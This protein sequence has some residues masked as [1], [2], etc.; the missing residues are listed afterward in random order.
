MPQTGAL[1]AAGDRGAR[2]PGHLGGVRPHARLG[3]HPA[4]RRGGRADRS[5]SSSPAISVR[6]ARPSSRTFEPFQQADMVFLESTYGDH[7]HRPFDGN[8]GGVRPHREGHG[9]AARQD[10]RARRSPWA[11]RNCSPACS[12]GCS[13]RRR[14]GPSPSSSTAPW[15]SRPPNI[16]A[17]HRELFDDAM[18]KFIAEKPLRDDLK[19]MKLCVTAEDSMKINDAARALP[20]HGRRRHVQ[21]RPHPAPPEAQPLESRTPTC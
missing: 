19:T 2:H 12:P 4:D 13:A 16:Y 10:P 6:E 20:G 8:G 3:Q 1:S 17:R 7:D 9:R 18:T 21:R 14:S 11:A 15:P 5:A